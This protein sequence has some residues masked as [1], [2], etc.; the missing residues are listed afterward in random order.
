MWFGN[1]GNV[2][3][4]RQNKFPLATLDSGQRT[5]VD[6]HLSE[7]TIKSNIPLNEGRSE[8]YRFIRKIERGGR[9]GPG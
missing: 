5:V 4:L 6:K 8:A 1:N 2:I 3:F 9:C 7:Q